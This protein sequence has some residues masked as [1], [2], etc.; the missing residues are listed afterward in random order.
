MPKKLQYFYTKLIL[1]VIYEYSKIFYRIETSNPADFRGKI[2][3][4][5]GTFSIL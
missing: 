3:C 2:V 1:N 4:I 5:R